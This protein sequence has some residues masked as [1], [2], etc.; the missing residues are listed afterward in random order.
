M[1]RGRDTKQRQPK[2][3]QVARQQPSQ[4]NPG[5]VERILRALL[6]QQ[7]PQRGRDD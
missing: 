1:S 4:P 7:Q 6:P 5:A 3:D 2:R